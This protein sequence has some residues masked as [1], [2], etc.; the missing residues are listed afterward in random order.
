V[1]DRIERPPFQMAVP[2]QHQR[3]APLLHSWSARRGPLL[4]QEV[5]SSSTRR[6][7]L[8]ETV[9]LGRHGSQLV[10]GGVQGVLLGIT[11]AVSTVI[12]SWIGTNSV[13]CAAISTRTAP[14]SSRTRCCCAARN[15]RVIHH[16][17]TAHVN[18]THISVAKR[19]LG[20]L[21]RLAHDH[22]MTSSARARIDG[23]TVMPRAS[24]VFKLTTSSKVVGCWTGRSA[25]FAP[26]RIRPA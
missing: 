12:S 5:R 10:E 23:G 6:S 1:L 26:L 25:G 9:L 22:S 14:N 21:T 15:S 11:I 8:T 7:P 18:Q 20:E 4:A 2:F 19:V 13:R 24:A 17:R 16:T 3:I